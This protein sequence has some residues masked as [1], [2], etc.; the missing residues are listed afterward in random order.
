MIAN[1]GWAYFLNWELALWGDPVYD[2][3]VHLHKMAYQPDEE[4]PAKAAWRNAVS[5]ETAAEWTTDLDTYLAHECVKSAV[6]DT[7]RYSKLIAAGT[8]SPAAQ[9]ALIDKLTT[10][11]HAA[12]TFWR[13]ANPRPRRGG[14][15][16]PQ[17]HPHDPRRGMISS[18]DSSG[19]L[20]RSSAPTRESSPLMPDFRPI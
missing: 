6:G 8:E 14:P 18:A 5:P 11:L 17:P 15:P 16:C 9:A 12:H 10:K 3:A 13:R 19:T 4:E 2:L 7:V 20:F 1:S